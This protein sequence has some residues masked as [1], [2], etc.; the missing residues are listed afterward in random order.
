MLQRL[1]LN[2]RSSCFCFPHAR[3]HCVRHHVQLISISFGLLIGLH[4]ALLYSQ[5]W[6][7]TDENPLSLASPVLGYP[8]YMPL[9][10]LLVKESKTLNWL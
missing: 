7:G 8:G 3:L 1:A 6:A 10:G 2:S 5:D 4:K 9:S